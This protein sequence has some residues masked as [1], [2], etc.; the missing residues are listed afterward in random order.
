MSTL[1]DSWLPLA[2]C[3]GLAIKRLSRLALQF[4]LG[5]LS[6]VNHVFA[7]FLLFFFPASL[8][9]TTSPNFTASCS[10]YGTAPVEICRSL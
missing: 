1:T 6:R 8:R 10:W 9:G 5:D 2:A 7:Y 3:G 4:L